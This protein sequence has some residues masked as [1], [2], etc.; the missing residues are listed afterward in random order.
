MTIKLE[1]IRKEVVGVGRKTERRKRREDGGERG[2][3]WYKNKD[4]KMCP[5]L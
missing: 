1:N 4:C 3:D 5:M 2:K